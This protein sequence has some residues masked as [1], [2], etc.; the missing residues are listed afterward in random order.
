MASCKS[1]P[2]RTRIV[3]PDE[4]TSAVSTY[5]LGGSGATVSFRSWD[6]A[7]AHPNAG[8]SNNPSSPAAATNAYIV[9]SSFGPEGSRTS[10]PDP[11][12][13]CIRPLSVNDAGQIEHEGRMADLFE[14][15]SILIRT[16]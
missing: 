2:S 12:I 15:C 11:L 5:S 6:G 10:P 9:D 14:E 4:G 1:S 13:P 8:V 3:C 7:P 16:F